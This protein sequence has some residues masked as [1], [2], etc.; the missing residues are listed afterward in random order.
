MKERERENSVDIAGVNKILS[1]SLSNT[2]TVVRTATDKWPLRTVVK[3]PNSDI[4]INCKIRTGYSECHSSHLYF[5]S[6]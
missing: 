5:L 3:L 2:V 4:I 6:V 1:Y